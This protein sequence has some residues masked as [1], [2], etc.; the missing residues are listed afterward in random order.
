MRRHRHNLIRRAQSDIER[1]GII[2]LDTAALL[3]EAGIVIEAFEQCLL[4]KATPCGLSY[5]S[6]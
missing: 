2:A 4:S 3:D 1:Y 5:V 6:T